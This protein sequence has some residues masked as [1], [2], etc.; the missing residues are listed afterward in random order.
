[1]PSEENTWTEVSI[2]QR[3]KRKRQK[4]E[5]SLE[6]ERGGERENIFLLSFLGRLFGSIWRLADEIITPTLIALENV[7]IIE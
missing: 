2:N 5:A 7:L 6:R 3:K 1:M 4:K